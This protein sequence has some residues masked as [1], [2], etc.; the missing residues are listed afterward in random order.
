VSPLAI[1]VVCYPGLGG[2]GVIASELA[3]ALA[4]RGHRVFVLATAM[5]ERLRENGV[6]F[7]RIEVPTSPVFDHAPYDL[8]VTTKLV[9]VARRERIDVIHVHYAVP[10][11]VSAMLAKQ[12]LG[13]ASPAI[14][15]TLHGT[16]VTRLGSLAEITGHALA[17][18]DAITAPSSYLR[19]AA[20]HLVA[21]ERIEV[22][23]NFVDTARFTPAQRTSRAEPVLFHV[24]NFRPIKRTRDLVDVLAAVRRSVPARM[25]LVGDG[26]E[27]V[28]VEAHAA[29]CGLADAMQ[30]LGRR[31]DFEHALRDADAF[32]LPSEME[33]F[34]VAALEAMAS[35]VPV[36][37][38]R[39]G[40]LPDVV[41]DTGALVAPGDVSALAAA[42]VDGLPRS[43]A[44]GRAARTRAE[45]FAREAV[46]DRYEAVLHRVA[47]GAR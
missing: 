37:G 13:A 3:R 39:V 11:A 38:Y 4:G 1:A 33:S 21:P 12:L 25:V 42:I 19:T 35:G 6:R 2:S 43:V 10:H 27:R 18:A 5:P 34:G 45:G 15:A 31:D 44:L 17:A 24:S 23:S 41:G 7:E 14:V 20:A 29:A 47:R 8:A 28:A 40:G 30:F 32:V 16:D 26:P 9:E 46:V 36:F 22:I